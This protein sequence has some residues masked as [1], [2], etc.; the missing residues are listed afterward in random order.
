VNDFDAEARAAVAAL[1]HRLRN[2]GDEDGQFSLDDEL[3]AQEFVLSLRGYGW[4]PVLVPP[5]EADWRKAS[6]GSRLP[7][8][9]KPGGAGYLAAKAALAARATGPQQVLTEDN[10]PWHGAGA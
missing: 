3:F 8:A 6:G 7:N 5:P 1:V 10:D 9:A 2:R 4:R